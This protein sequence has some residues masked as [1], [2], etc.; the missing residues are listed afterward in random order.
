MNNRNQ[1]SKA[2]SRCAVITGIL[3]IITSAIHA[4]DINDTVIGIKTGDIAP[5]H[6]A[7]AIS[8]WIFSGIAMLLL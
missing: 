3:L 5:S 4:L 2:V 7:S 1:Q 8:V 6:A